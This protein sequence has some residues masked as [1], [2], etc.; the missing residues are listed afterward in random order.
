MSPRGRIRL[1][2]RLR[3][4]LTIMVVFVTAGAG[5]LLAQYMI[6]RQ[7]FS[8]VHVTAVACPLPTGSAESVDPACAVTRAGEGS[9]PVIDPTAT[10]PGMRQATFLVDSVLEGV[11]TWSVVL[12]AVFTVVAAG[13]AFW[14]ARRPMKR[15]AEV[16]AAAREISDRELDRRLELPGPPDEI[17]ELGDTFDSMLDRLHRSF[18]ARDRFVANASHELRTPL[19]VARSSLEIPLLQGDVPDALVPAVERALRAT[20]QSEELIAALLLLA[21]GRAG[22]RDTESVDVVALV[23]EVVSEYASVA[24]EKGVD[25][26]W[27]GVPAGAPLSVLANPALLDRAVHNLVDNALAYNEPAGWVRVRVSEVDDDIR[28]DVENTGRR[29]SDDEAALL[30]EPFFRGSQSRLASPS[31]GTGLGLSIVDS[32]VATHGGRL[33]VVAREGGG[34]LAQITLP[35]WAPTDGARWSVDSHDAVM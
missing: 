26:R 33:D 35:R 27:Q 24:R 19:T 6:V 10:T 31:R 20:E 2:F 32:V 8:A 18:A 1:G 5:L 34:L 16:T 28:I 4:G 23:R 29:I 25:V 14:L 3:L 11:L 9:S 15:I 13:A 17:T 30:V 21:R 12:L 22:T 7:L